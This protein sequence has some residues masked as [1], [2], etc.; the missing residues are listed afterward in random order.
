LFE[1]SFYPPKQVFI[2]LEKTIYRIPRIMIQQAI[3]LNAFFSVRHKATINANRNKAVEIKD[4]P[5]VYGSI[6]M[7]YQAK[8]QIGVNNI[9]DIIHFFISSGVIF[10]PLLSFYLSL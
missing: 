2:S 7:K 10:S 8:I 6:D 5:Q 3:M 1:K 9:I 4:T